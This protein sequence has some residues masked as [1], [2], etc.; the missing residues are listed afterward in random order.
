MTRTAL[1]IGAGSIGNHHSFAARQQSFKVTV[2]DKDIDALERMKNDIY[3]SRYGSW[4]DSITLLN[5]I[6]ECEK[7]GFDFVIIGTPPDSHLSILE[8]VLNKIECSIILIEKPLAS[9][10]GDNLLNRLEKLNADSSPRLLVAYNHRFTE[11]TNKFVSRMLDSTLIMPQFIS[12]VFQESWEGIFRAHPWLDGP[13]DSYLGYLERGGGAAYEHSH[14]LNLFLFIIEIL[15]LGEIIY[16][17]QHGKVTTSDKLFYDHHYSSFFITSKGVSGLVIQDVISKVNS[18]SLRIDYYNGSLEWVY[19]Y[20]DSHHAIISTFSD[21][22]ETELIKANRTED[23][24][25]QMVHIKNLLDN[26]SLDSALDFK[27][28]I[29]TQKILEEYYIDIIKNQ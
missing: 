22:V 15:N 23:F 27:R 4:D 19:G 17:K 20:D 28:N 5:D 24:R 3:P 9:P 26:P 10:L 14:A 6:T 18:K 11:L 8:Y 7:T 29:E 25:G 12:C 1:I 2:Y 21:K 13:G 16:K